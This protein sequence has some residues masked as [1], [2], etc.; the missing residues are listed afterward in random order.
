MG[1]VMHTCP[2]CGHTGEPQRVDG[3]FGPHSIKQVCAQCGAFIGWLSS[4]NGGRKKRPAK[5]CELAKRYGQGFCE[6]CRRHLDNLPIEKRWF[7]GHH[8]VEYQDGGTDDRTNVMVLCP[9]CHE[10]V[11]LIRRHHPPA[12][13][14]VNFF[15]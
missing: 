4:G 15:D 14:P 9:M 8:I 12:N 6:I 13:K 5:H 11:H 10:L 1:F 7:E 3:S 2:K